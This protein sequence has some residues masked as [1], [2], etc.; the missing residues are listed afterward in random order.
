MV[1]H[2]APGAQIVTFALEEE[3]GV[4][5]DGGAGGLRQ[6][7]GTGGEWRIVGVRDFRI[8]V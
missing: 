4:L 5:N 3:Q 8:G 1:G 7:A 2:D 6:N